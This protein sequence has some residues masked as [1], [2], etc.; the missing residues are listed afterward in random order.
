MWNWTCSSRRRTSRGRSDQGVALPGVLLL[1]AFLVG[2]TGWMVGHLRT[3]VGLT[4]AVEDAHAA[5]RLAE[6]A[7]QAVALA[8]AQQPDWAVVD[9]LDPSLPC[10]GAQTMVVPLDVVAE[11]GWIQAE[12]AAG[13]RW[14]ADTPEWQPV[15]VCHAA[16][17]LGRWPVRGPTPAV[18]VWVADDPEGDGQPLRSVN[19]RLLVTAVARAAGEARG[20]ASATL[21]RAAPGARVELAS[22]RVAAGL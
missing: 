22:W 17:V 2:V 18:S 6:A 1:A 9:A 10:S 4:T 19:Q 13:S 5:A 3:D 16:G 12:I 20:A 14:G 7:V 11:R 15:W 8:L 21:S